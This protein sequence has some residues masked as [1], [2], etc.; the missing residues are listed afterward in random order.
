MALVGFLMYLGLTSYWSEWHFVVVE[1]S[2][3]MRV[4][5]TLGVALDCQIRLI[6]ILVCG[7]SQSYRFGGK[8][9]A[10]LAKMLRKWALKL[11]MATS[12]ALRLWQP[13]GTN[14]ISS[15]HVSRM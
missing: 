14:S 8:L 1:G 15:L 5:K 13:G 10:T 11:C 4:S 9:L 2:A 6:V 7:S 3:E 12:A